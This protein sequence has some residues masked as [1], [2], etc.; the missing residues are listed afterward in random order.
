MSVYC[1]IHFV[2][3][4]SLHMPSCC[5]VIMIMV[6]CETKIFTFRCMSVYI[7]YFN[8]SI[9]VH[10]LF[11]PGQGHYGYGVFPGNTDCEAGLHSEWDTNPL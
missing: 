3:I 11:Y 2:S 9:H 4:L 7:K 5:M 10:Y 6:E 8:L 1:N